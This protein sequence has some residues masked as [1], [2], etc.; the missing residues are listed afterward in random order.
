MTNII[1][2]ELEI[3]RCLGMKPNYSE[4]ARIHGIS[5]QTISKYD[6]GFIKQETRNKKSKLDQY[7]DEII[8]KI[9]L[10]GA[11]ITG[12]YKYFYN[13]DKTI[14]SRSNFD[15]YVRKHKLKEKKK[16]IRSSKIWDKA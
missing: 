4:W 15:Y 8:E 13:K 2:A 9:N 7:R 10:P 5:R 14:C 1:E 3:L 11:T 16:I 6:K 12:V